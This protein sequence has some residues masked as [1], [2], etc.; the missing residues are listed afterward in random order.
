ML[1][2][3]NID[4]TGYLI[5]GI[6]DTRS[7][8]KIVRFTEIQRNRSVSE[9]VK[10]NLALIVLIGL[11]IL[12]GAASISGM[13]TRPI[14][15]LLVCMKDV[16]NGTL[17]RVEEGAKLQEFR[18]L[19]KGYNHMID[20]IEVLIQE[21]IE[22][23]RRIR[24]VELNEVQEQMKPHFLYN[25]LDSIEALA[26]MGDT[27]KV[28]KLVEALGDFYRKSVSGGREFLSI[29]EEFQMAKDYAEIM[30]IRFGE[31]FSCDIELEDQCCEYEIP[32][33]TIQPL[34]ENAFQ[35]GIRTKKK[36]GHIRV[37]CSMKEDKIHIMVMD[38]GDG[39]PEDVVEELAKDKEPGMGKS[40]GL[41]GTIERLRLLYGEGFSYRIE[42]ERES[43][44]H[45]YIDAKILREQRDGKIKSNTD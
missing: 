26:M 5:S 31:T 6:I 25:T 20:R 29:K 36:Y 13:L 21:I 16:E 9:I 41:R 8:W 39:V 33:L 14:Q 23:Q 35:H 10:F 24:Q 19:F 32:K 4:H 7:R 1:E 22:R 3:K 11:V 17:T 40:L 42:N 34:V 12:I 43:E 28:C 2:S 27:E 38:N 18:I 37:G 30:K 44:I 45:L 15:Q